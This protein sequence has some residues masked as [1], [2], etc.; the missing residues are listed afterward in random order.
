[1]LVRMNLELFVWR[2]R[3][4]GSLWFVPTVIIMAGIAA[5]VVLTELDRAFEDAGTD[6]LFEGSPTSARTVM[7]TIGAS[8]LAII[9]VSVPLT[10]V[11]LQLVAGQFSQRILRNFLSD[12]VVQT[13]L[14]VFVAVFAYSLLVLRVITDADGAEEAFVPNVAVTAGIL[15]ALASLALF[16]FFINHIMDMIQL[17]NIIQNI[18]AETRLSM[19]SLY[20]EAVGQAGDAPPVPDPP[21]DAGR[22]RAAKSGY[23]QAVDVAALFHIAEASDATIWVL[24]R[25]GEFCA[26]GSALFAGA[27]LKDD[28]HTRHQLNHEVQIGGYRTVENDALF[29][30]RQIVDIAARALSPGV[31][32]PTTAVQCLDYLQALLIALSQREFTSPV[33]KDAGGNERLIVA[34]PV[35]EDY[36]G[37]SFN[38]I[39]E[40]GEGN[41]AVMRRLVD[42]IGE[43]LRET[44]SDSRR[45]CLVRHMQ[46]TLAGARRSISEPEDLKELEERAAAHLRESV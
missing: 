23:L 41:V 37:E 12:R 11:A 20:P 26:E 8:V 24:R 1:M 5:A 34:R 7:G 45:E 21:D 13:F 17:T 25:P 14:G 16:V 28:D 46:L 19:L 39:R 3:L 40:F 31:N 4:F 22:V 9:G 18:S 29:G 43:V 38:Q 6:I 10:I 2:E 15:A 44:H 35:F 30:F 42:A 33:R 27:G 32:D 36:A